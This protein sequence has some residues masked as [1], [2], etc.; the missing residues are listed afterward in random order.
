MPT[1]DNNVNN[2]SNGVTTGTLG[3]PGG[4]ILSGPITL[5]DATEPTDDGDTDNNTNLTLDFGVVPPATAGPLT[6][7]DTVF[8]DVNNNGTLDTGETGVSGVVVEL[9]DEAGT[10][11]L[12]TTT[13]SASG[14]YTFN[15]LDA[16][17]YRVRLAASNFTGSGVLVGFTASTTTAADPDDDLNNDNDGVT[18]GTLGSGGVILSGPITLADGDRT[19]RRRRHGQRTP[20]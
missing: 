13:T 9:L 14:V 11:V 2:D 12:A 3:S 4:V 16:D 6:L 19:E 7:G 1:P 8:R 10:T 18:S 15:G 20:T 17:T 5:A